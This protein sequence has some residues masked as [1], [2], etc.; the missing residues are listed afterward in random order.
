LQLL[1][2]GKYKC[3]VNAGLSVLFC[4]LCKPNSSF[5]NVT[6]PALQSACEK[7]SNCDDDDDDDGNDNFVC[8]DLVTSQLASLQVCSNFSNLF[9]NFDNDDDDDDDDVGD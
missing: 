4:N 6:M 8:S 5:I 2:G 3:K 7:H 9:G 1:Y